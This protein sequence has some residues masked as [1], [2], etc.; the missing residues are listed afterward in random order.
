MSIAIT[1]DGNVVVSD[2]GNRAWIVFRPTG[3]HVRSVSVGDGLRSPVGVSA[4]RRG[5]VLVRQGEPLAA[6]GST[7]RTSSVMTSTPSGSSCGA[8]RRAGGER[9][10]TRAGRRAVL[11]PAMNASH[12]CSRGP[13]GLTMDGPRMAARRGLRARPGHPSC[14]WIW[15]CKYPDGFV[16]LRWPRSLWPCPAPVSITA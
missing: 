3:E 12:A 10:A 8:C 4:D 1:S 2:L 15:Q 9:D 6:G 7:A 5:G 16:S 14:A 13:P 11:R